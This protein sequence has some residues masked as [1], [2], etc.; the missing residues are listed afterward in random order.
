MSSENVWLKQRD[1]E[2]LRRLEG[3]FSWNRYSGR[4][5]KDFIIEKGSIP[6]MISAPHSVNHKRDGKLKYADKLTGGI[7]RYIHKVTGCHIIYSTRTSTGDPNFDGDI[8]SAYK[9]ELKRYVEENNIRVLIDLHG[10]SSNRPYAVELGTVDSSDSSLKKYTFISDLVTQYLEYFISNIGEC[11][12]RSIWKN[13]LFSASFENTI[14]SFISR[15]TETACIQLEVNGK[16]RN[17]ED[18]GKLASVLHALV[19]LVTTLGRLDWEVTQEFRVYKVARSADHKQQDMIQLLDYDYE[20]LNSESGTLTRSY[21]LVKEDGA[22]EIVSLGRLSDKTLNNNQH[23]LSKECMKDYLFL[24]NRLIREIYNREWVT[25]NETYSSIEGMPIVLCLHTNNKYNFGIPTV[26]K[27]SNITFSST[28]YSRLSKVFNSHDISVYNRFSGKSIY[29]D[30]LKADYGDNGRVREEKVMMPLFYK[31]II[32]YLDYPLTKMTSEGYNHFCSL[33]SNCES[34]EIVERSYYK[35]MNGGYSLSIDATESDRYELGLV[36]K[37][38]IGESCEVVLSSRGICKYLGLCKYVLCSIKSVKEH[39]LTIFVG[40]AETSLCTTWTYLIDDKNNVARLH[41]STMNVL[42]VVENDKIEIKYGNKKEVVRVLESDD[43]DM[44][45]IGIPAL[46]RK[47]LEMNNVNGI[48]SVR[49][50][51]MHTL[52]KYSTQQSIT[53]LGTVITVLSLFSDVVTGSVV[54]CILYPVML[55]W[56]LSEERGKVG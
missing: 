49:R 55:F 12:T 26:D 14:T 39:V 35:D 33:V 1:V 6:I 13:R 24:P 48:V 21:R 45:T 43:I 47:V 15:N 22:M 29:I 56:V 53:F 28:L 27:V 37:K 51:M 34:K 32:D 3:R 54:A 4:G 8:D 19:E 38:Y 30:F 36:Q 44:Y 7:A 40:Y 42:G 10:A 11:D 9:R 23:I 25:E 41:K 52:K 46:T 17:L 18:T 20:H 2:F 31:K 50:S 5:N 16:F